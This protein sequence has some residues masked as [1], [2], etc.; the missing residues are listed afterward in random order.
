MVRAFALAWFPLFAHAADP[1][2]PGGASDVMTAEQIEQALHPPPT[3]SLQTHDFK[4]RGLM[5]RHAAEAPTA[6]PAADKPPAVNL[7]IAFEYNS[8]NLKPQ[9]SAQ[10]K[11]LAKAL[12]SDSLAKDRFL[13]AG[14]TDAKGSAAY[15]QHLSLRRADAVKGFLVASGI[16]ANRLDTIGYGSEQLLLPDQPLDPSNRRVEIR[17]LGA[18]PIPPPR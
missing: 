4:K 1:A 13:V 9:A 5:R 8:S 11:L 10:L 18:G 12:T 2:P 16:E 14:H 17:D 3:R 15:N 6:P 7:N